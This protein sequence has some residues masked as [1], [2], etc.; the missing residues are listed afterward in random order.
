[1]EFDFVSIGRRIKTARHRSKITQEK[2]AELIDVSNVY[3]YYIER[4]E[5]RASLVLLAQ[6]ARVLEMSLDDLVFGDETKH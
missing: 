3:I 2:L 5:R 1:M 6:I 4:G